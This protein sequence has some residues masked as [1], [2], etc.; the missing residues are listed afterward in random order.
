[1]IFLELIREK[2]THHVTVAG[3]HARRVGL[4][5]QPRDAP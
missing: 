3:S 2:G 5:A 1:M 4:I